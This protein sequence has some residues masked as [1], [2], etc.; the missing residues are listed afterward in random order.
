MK[1]YILN[2]N[3]ILISLLPK[4]KY[5]NTYDHL[6]SCAFRCETEMCGCKGR[7]FVCNE[8][9]SLIYEH[10]LGFDSFQKKHKCKHFFLRYGYCH[11]LR[12]NKCH[13]EGLYD[14]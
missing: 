10:E 11:S 12:L 13:L 14:A 1:K 8:R 7:C 3:H 6:T 2:I 9:C 5:K 4:R